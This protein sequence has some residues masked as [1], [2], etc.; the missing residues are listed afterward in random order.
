VLRQ[1]H[2]ILL[3]SYILGINSNF[4]LAEEG[5]SQSVIS[6]P[7]AMSGSTPGIVPE[8][9]VAAPIKEVQQDLVFTMVPK[10]PDRT[11]KGELTFS[12]Q[13]KRFDDPVVNS[14]FSR[15][16]ISVELESKY[17][18]FL[19]ANFGASQ[20]LTS[21]QATNLYAVTEGGTG[22]GLFVDE[23]SIS[24]I[25]IEGLAVTAGIIQVSLNP[26]YSQFYTQSNAGG[27]INYGFIKTTNKFVIEASQSIPTSKGTSNAVIDDGYLPL[28]TVFSAKGET[29]FDSSLTTVKVAATRFQFT[30]PSSQ[31]A[32]DS[33][34]TGS[35]TI[36]NGKGGFL[37][38]YDFRG[39][40]LAAAVEQKIFLEDVVSIKG[41]RVKNDLAPEGLNQGWMARA[42]YSRAFNK[43]A[44]KPS[45]TRF[46]VESD[47]LP[48]VYTMPANGF[49]NRD[50]A[51]YAVKLDFPKEK[52]N[53]FGSYVKANVIDQNSTAG[54]FQADREVYVIGA[55]AKYDIF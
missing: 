6:A 25:P 14:R 36:G 45:F 47:A 5:T 44:V 18:D 54:F 42:E 24:L 19:K 4:A 50:G 34:Q 3:V 11:Y 7:A 33:Q 15:A 32:A 48:S 35:T 1:F 2:I 29:T 43:Y 26:V 13:G 9:S 8:A 39:T 49:T 46:H 37:F 22:S 10:N 23:A 20:L 51:A 38:A 21:G 16:I 55:E 30:D 53:V 31:S 28:L 40:E 27:L 17:K 12:L 52:F 41:N